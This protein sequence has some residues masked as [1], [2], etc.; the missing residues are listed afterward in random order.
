[1]KRF[2]FILFVAHVCLISSGRHAW[3]NGVIRD[4][5]GAT[6]SGRGGTNIGHSDTG[7]VILDNPA[8]IINVN[9]NGL[10]EFGIDTVITDLDY[11]D[12]QNEAAS[13]TR[14]GVLPQVSI[15]RKT[16]DGRWA[17]GLGIYAPAGYSATWTLNNP[18]LG[19]NAY[20]SFGA[21]GKIMP[22]LAYRVNDKLSIGGTFGVSVS[23]LE[24]ETPFFL[25]TGLLAGAP[26]IFDLQATGVTPSWSV[27]TQY[28]LGPCTTIGA[29]FIGESRF[30]YDGSVRA[31]VFGLGPDP[32]QS[33]FD[34]DVKLAWPRSAGIG[35]VHSFC[36]CQRFS[37]D[38]VWYDW[39][40]AYDS[41]DLK[42]KN[43][44]NQ[45]INGMLGP[46]VTDSFPLNWKDSISVRI[47]YEW[48]LR[49]SDVCR[50]GYVHNSR[51]L[52][53]STLTPLIPA[54]LEHSFTV[55][56]GTKWTKWRFDCAYQ[57]SF[58]PDR[59]V[60]TS[61]LAGGDFSGSG[62]ESQAHWITLS[63]LRQF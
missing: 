59:T 42:L 17:Y 63:L 25:Q 9:G 3:S 47:G 26:T 48:F 20:K 45:M 4:S 39:S 30:T 12:P 52:P 62:V 57:Y 36:N 27:G 33:N 7:T 14:P 41:V 53:S 50:V 19:N 10:F 32:L 61:A 21:L 13:K 16:E 38:V 28:Q 6:S 29:R 51:N 40:H 8:A 34:A 5:M 55:G 60:G 22:A 56:Y 54:T 58:A 23:H 1:M 43:G 24:L 37:A 44:S 49:N 35:L 2:A 31:T 46:V 18:L 11:G 15:I